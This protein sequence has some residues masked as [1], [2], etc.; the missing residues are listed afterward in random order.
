MLM[1]GS[2]RGVRLLTLGAGVA[3]VLGFA[4][5]IGAIPAAAA[6]S[7]GGWTWKRTHADAANGLACPT[8]K[9]C[10]GI[11]G[12]KVAWTTDPSAAM[13][14]WKRTGLERRFPQPVQGGV[15]LDALSC[16][17]A[18]FCIT[19]DN[20][21]NTFATTDPTGGKRAW[22]EVAVDGIEILRIGCASA[23]LC[24]A[25]D[26]S[27]NVLTSTDPGSATPIWRSVHLTTMMSAEFYGVSCA[28]QSLCA[29][30]EGSAKIYTTSNANAASPT[31]HHV[32]VPSHGWDGVSCPTAGRCIAVGTFDFGDKVAVSKDPRVAKPSWK[33]A[34]LH[35][36]GDFSGLSRIDC[37]TR[38]FCFAMGDLF[39]TH[40][41][42][43]RSAWHGTK[44]PTMS[45]Q[46]EVSCP[47][48]LRCFVATSTDD[49][50]AGRR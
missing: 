31:W 43:M 19:A 2:R 46:T 22:H 39:T 12:N 3:L 11:D 50:L 16:P 18:G 10:V 5:P 13:P 34:K 17:T 27:G 4:A 15:I 1:A 49:L 44:L 20:L 26:Y 41:A 37:A 21:G 6:H 25:L 29:A 23:S 45:S 14:R 35:G 7:S 28:G 33:V 42:A 32:K 40:V 8:T 36:S 9:L 30:V 47:T 38:S 48:T 24:A